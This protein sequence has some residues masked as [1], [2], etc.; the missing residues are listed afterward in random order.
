ME[1]FN[2][3]EDKEA[4]G[5]T[6]THAVCALHECGSSVVDVTSQISNTVGLNE[7]G[8]GEGDELR[9]DVLEGFPQ[10]GKRDVEVSA[11]A[12]ALER[13]ICESIPNAENG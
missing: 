7:G 12:H 13:K 6:Y 2:R 8:F 11:A 9:F 3:L 1:D 4:Y 10:C 5:E